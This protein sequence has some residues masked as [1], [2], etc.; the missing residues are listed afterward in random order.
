MPGNK[1]PDAPSHMCPQVA[2]VIG[3]ILSNPSVSENKIVEVVAETDAPLVSLEEQLAAL[4]VTGLTQAERVEKQRQ[5]EE[6]EAKREQERRE[7]GEQQG[8]M[9][10]GCDLRLPTGVFSELSGSL[11]VLGTR[12]D[13][14]RQISDRIPSNAES[15]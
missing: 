2:E 6:E 4:P 14:Q 13:E 8:G 7:A 3:A 12:R 1:G 5:E 11:E 15:L 10:S 9:G